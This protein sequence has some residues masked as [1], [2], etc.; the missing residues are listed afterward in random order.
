[1]QRGEEW[2]I[3]WQSMRHGRPHTVLTLTAGLWLC[4]ALIKLRSHQEKIGIRVIRTSLSEKIQPGQMRQEWGLFPTCSY[5]SH[6]P[7]EKQRDA[8]PGPAATTPTLFPFHRVEGPHNG[9]PCSRLLERV[10]MLLN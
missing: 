5:C 3:E 6:S 9:S 8:G 4:Y 2:P 7:S 10:S 1:M